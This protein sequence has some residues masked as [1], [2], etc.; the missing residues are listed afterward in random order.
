MKYV[1]QFTRATPDSSLVI[2]KKPHVFFTITGASLLLICQL[3]DSERYIE[4]KPDPRSPYNY[5]ETPTPVD[6]TKVTPVKN[7]EGANKMAFQY[8][9]MRASGPE[10]LEMILTPAPQVCKIFHFLNF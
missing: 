2:F 8:H 7:A 5:V 9:E 6:L 10:G 1:A 3:S 4:F